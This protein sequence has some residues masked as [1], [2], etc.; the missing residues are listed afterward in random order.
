MR[1]T[2][3]ALIALTV[4]AGAC[5]DH[6]YD[7]DGP[8]IDPN[9]PKIHITSPDRGAIA[10]DVHTVTVTGTATD[11]TGVATVTVN[12]VP[13]TLAADGTWT[14]IVPVVPGTNLLHA[15]ATDLSSNTGKESRSVVAGPMSNLAMQVPNALTASLSAQTFDAI[16]RGAAGYIKTADL[17][18]IIS[19]SNPVIHAGDPDGPDCLYGEAAITSMTVGDVAVTLAPQA[20]GLYLDAEL[21]TVKIGMHLQY[22]VS[23]LD[24]SR[25]I[26]IA[27]SHISVSGNMAVG[28]TATNDFDITLDNPNVQLTGFDLELGGVPGEIVDLLH[29]DTALGPVIG[30][31]TEKFVTPMLNTSLAGLN[32][33]KTMTVLNSQV[34]I[35]IKPSKL[36]FSSAGAIIELDT[37]IRAH[38]DTGKFVFVDNIVPAMDLSHGFSL[39]VADDAANQAFAS[40]WSA[41]GLDDSI[42]LNNGSYGDIGTLYDSVEI[43]TMAPPFVDASN[44]ANGLVLTIGDLMASFKNGAQTTTEAA[45]NAQVGLKVST[46]SDGTIKFDV[47]QPT[48]YVDV[49]DEGV[50]GANQLSN[51]Q[52]EAVTS[53]ALARVIAVGS[54]S[55][56]SIPLP[57]IGGVGVTDIAINPQTGYLVIAGDVQ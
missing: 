18:A 55:L 28:L 30:W 42:M 53:F 17:E 31:A 41:K 44:P 6:P 51:A 25:D 2:L 36:D 5:T 38:G 33:T 26:T 7:P 32:T 9:A 37:S 10:G 35:S 52:F 29:I 11:D 21:S 24:G 19:P 34:D 1:H 22:A 14:A 23:C 16:G 27:A 43:A 15:I 47:G 56:G 8:A 48:V 49:L 50:E 20:G 39:A 12:D 46:G 3:F 45:I 40:M 13:A 4:S 57:S 54:A